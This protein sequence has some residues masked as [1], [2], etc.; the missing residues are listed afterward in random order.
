MTTSIPASQFVSVLPGVLGTGGSGKSLNCVM[1]DNSGDTSIPAGTVQ[2]FY[3]L[4]AVQ[5]WYGANSQQALLAAVYFSGF[6]NCT[7]LPGVLYF[8]QDTSSAVA[9]YLR[10]GTTAG[11]TLTQLQAFTGTLSVTVNGTLYTTGSLNLSAATSFSEAATTILQGGFTALTAPVTVTYDALRQ[12]FV[13]TSTTTGATSTMTVAGGT[14][15]ADLN[16][17]TA[18]GAVLSQGVAA[19]TAATLMNGVLAVQ[20]NWATF[21]TVSQPTLTIMEAFAAWVNAQNEQY[22]YVNWDSNVVATETPPQSGVFGQIVAGYNGCVSVYDAV[23]TIAAFVCGAIASTNYNALNGYINYAAKSNPLLTPNV[24]NLQTY[25]NLVGNGYNCYAGVATANQNFQWFE[26]GSVSGQWDFIDELAFAIWMTSQLQTA[27]MQ[28]LA[29]VNT[30][31]FNQTGKSLLYAAYLGPIQ[32][33]LN[34]GG[35][36]TGILL[37]PAQIA[38]INQQAGSTITPALYQQGFW[39]SLPLPS[40]SVQSARGPWSGTLWYTNAGGVN[41]LS[42]ASINVQ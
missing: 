4:A 38:E 5:S 3:N 22:I 6:T 2:P 16:L 15:S 33:G 17:T 1:V 24:T 8:T 39:L 28:L 19:T 27:G 25:L 34:C 14:L 35:I 18:T 37:T 23:G 42:L 10:G 13:I 12:A 21:M 32:A 41:T 11:M 7:Q 30:I 9:A 40:P 31:P 20:Q 29:N 26:P 36:Q